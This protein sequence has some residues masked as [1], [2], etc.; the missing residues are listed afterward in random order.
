MLHCTGSEKEEEMGERDQIVDQYILAN[1]ICLLLTMV[2]KMKRGFPTLILK[3]ADD[4]LIR[5][6]PIIHLNMMNY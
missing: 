1:K 4:H 6:T 5:I 2:I 3:N